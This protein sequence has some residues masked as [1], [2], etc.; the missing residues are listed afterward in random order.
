MVIKKKG[1]VY[2]IMTLIGVGW[3]DN[4]DNSLEV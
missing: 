2:Y 3:I 4:N 1:N